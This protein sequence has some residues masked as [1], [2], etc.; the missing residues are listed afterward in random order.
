MAKKNII[1]LLL[2]CANV[3]L[4]IAQTVDF[5]SVDEFFKITTILKEGKDV[6]VEQWEEFENSSGYKELRQNSM[7]IIKSMIN[8]VFGKENVAVKDSILSIT[9]DEMDKNP[10]MLVKKLALV[11]YLD[12]ND[13]YESLMSFRANYDF[14]ALVE[15]AIQRLFLFLKNHWIRH[16]NS[17]L[18]ISSLSVLM[19]LLK[20]TEYVLTLT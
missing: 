19:E 3:N 10:T 13:N 4:P 8:V 9:K 6:S 11:N 14:N 5:S 18:L 12:I 7:N 1:G 16:L 15:K 20:K 17:N 2:L